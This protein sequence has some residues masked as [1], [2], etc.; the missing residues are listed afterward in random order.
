METQKAALSVEEAAAFTGYSKHYIRKL[1]F[2]KRIPYYKP[3]G[4]RVFFRLTEL[5]QW[6]FKNPQGA[7]CETLHT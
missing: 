2:L 6:L 4:G 1:V 3:M 5:E 7:D